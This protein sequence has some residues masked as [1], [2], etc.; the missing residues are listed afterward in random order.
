MVT[1]VD[2]SVTVITTY[3]EERDNTTQ[4]IPMEV[5]DL[6][7]FSCLLDNINLTNELKSKG[8]LHFIIFFESS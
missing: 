8:E 3:L 6:P 1:E 7:M 2:E 5:S 4:A